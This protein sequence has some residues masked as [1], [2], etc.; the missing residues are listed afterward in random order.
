VADFDAENA[1]VK[2]SK[3]TDYLLALDHRIGGPKARYF[4]SFGFDPSRPEE[5]AHA[6]REHARSQRV[7][8]EEDTGYGTKWTVEGTLKCPDGRSPSIRTVWMLDTDA[9][10]PR[11]VTAYPLQSPEIDA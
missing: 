6:L 10:F 11:L 2:E 8:E 5:F 9:E 7:G 3:I 1:I 4:R